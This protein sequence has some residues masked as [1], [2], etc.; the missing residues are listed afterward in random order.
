MV[1]VENCRASTQSSPKNVPIFFALIINI[2]LVT[3]DRFLQLFTLHLFQTCQLSYFCFFD[4]SLSWQFTGIFLWIKNKTYKET[5]T[6]LIIHITG[7][8]NLPIRK[9]HLFVQEM[10]NVFSTQQLWKE[11]MHPPPSKERNRFFLAIL[12]HA[13][14]FHTFS[15][16][17]QTL[18]CDPWQ[19]C[20]RERRFFFWKCKN[21]MQKVIG[22]CMTSFVPTREAWMQRIKTIV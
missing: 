20:W 10:K 2:Y 15:N 17:E 11:I 22:N 3:L 1:C 5:N 14:L 6:C 13:P 8:Y 18:G 12:N 4:T 9:K 19:G 21:K 7:Y 16:Q